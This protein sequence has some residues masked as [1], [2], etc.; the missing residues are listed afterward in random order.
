[1]CTIKVENDGLYEHEPFLEE[2]SNTIS[3]V[4]IKT[5]ECDPL[6]LDSQ[7]I[8]INESIL[9]SDRIKCETI[10]NYENQCEKT[11]K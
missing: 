10:D 1:M 11:F 2:Q 7:L 8:L 3:N 5:E 6:Q 4:E 9:D